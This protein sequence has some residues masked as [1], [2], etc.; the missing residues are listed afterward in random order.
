MSLNFSPFF[1][2]FFNEPLQRSFVQKASAAEHHRAIS[3]YLYSC[4][5]FFVDMEKYKQ[6]N[7]VLNILPEQGYWLKKH[8]MNDKRKTQSFKQYEKEAVLAI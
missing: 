1:F 6:I 4:C 5:C 8:Q 7:I 3:D 2:L